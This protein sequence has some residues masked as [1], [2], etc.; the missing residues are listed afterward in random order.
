MTAQTQ[1]TKTSMALFVTEEMTS[2]QTDL[3]SIGSKMTSCNWTCVDTCGKAQKGLVNKTN[4]ID[5]CKCFN[6]ADLE[7]NIAK[8]YNKTPNSTPVEK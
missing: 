3:Q 5:T 6:F 2:L 1:L 7:A 8:T 4:C